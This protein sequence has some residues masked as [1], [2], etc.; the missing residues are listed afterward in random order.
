MRLALRDDGSA[1]SARTVLIAT[2]HFTHQGDELEMTSGISPR[3]AQS[4]CTIRELDKLVKGQL[5]RGGEPVILAG[6]LNDPYLPTHLL[7]EAG[8][9]SCFAVL[10]MQSPSTWPSY[11]T[12]GIVAGDPV[13]SQTIDWIVANDRV[14]PICA[15][16][17]KCFC[18]D[19][20]PSDHWP[21]Q[22]V[23]ELPGE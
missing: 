12:A 5:A 3:Y 9:K 6:D 19:V 14:R 13:T 2:V 8:Y 20:T 10:G 16:V 1:D 17:P 21:V 4:R 11:P 7:H 15:Q 22:A 18:D 23:Y